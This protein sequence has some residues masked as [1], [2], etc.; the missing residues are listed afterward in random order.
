MFIALVATESAESNVGRGKKGNGFRCHRAFT[1]SI[2]AFGLSINGCGLTSATLEPMN[3]PLRDRMMSVLGALALF[4]AF[5]GCSS[6]YVGK[7]VG[8]KPHV[9][10]PEEWNSAWSAGGEH[11]I[12]VVTDA[13]E[14]RLELVQTKIE[15]RAITFTRYAAFVRE[16]GD[17]L[18]ISVRADSEKQQRYLWGRLKLRDG[19]AVVWAPHVEKFRGWVRGGKMKGTAADTGDVELAELTATDLQAIVLNEALMPFHWD[20]PIVFHRVT[21]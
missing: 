14:G 18:F 17:V 21:P 2:P 19:Q 3:S 13:A 11:G 20:E 16:V 6:V 9:L 15:N 12:V 4:G 5:S 10:K 7:P 1:E 8:E